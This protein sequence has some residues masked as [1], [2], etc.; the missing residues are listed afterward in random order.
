MLFD[1]EVIPEAGSP[2]TL[3]FALEDGRSA[4]M[5]VAARAAIAFA[6]TIRELALMFDP[7]SEVRVELESGSRGSLGL[8]ALIKRVKGFAGSHPGWTAFLAGALLQV[9]GDVRAWTVGEIMTLLKGGDAPAEVQHLSDDEHHRIA[10]EVVRQLNNP[11]VRESSRQ[12]F[13]EVQKDPA[14][15]GVG[16]TSTP[17]KI[18]D[19]IVP[20]ELFEYARGEHIAEI[21]TPKSRVELEELRV[22][23]KKL[24]LE[25]VV[26]S[27]RFQ[28]G[29]LPEFSAEMRDK[30]FLRAFGDGRIDLPLRIGTEM[31]VE[32]ETEQQFIG[33]VWVT[34]KRVINRVLW[35]RSTPA[36]LELFPD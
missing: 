4:D 15:K 9:G 27:W 33:G 18:P 31:V 10:E 34:H 2:I 28:Y 13:R 35:P 19:F 3:Y 36:G 11:T 7:F 16:V 21:I 12:I 30:D 23:V 24:R 14:I 20:R 8:N 5:E 26:S 29:S 17:G 6:E 25:A 32:L 1:E 22:T